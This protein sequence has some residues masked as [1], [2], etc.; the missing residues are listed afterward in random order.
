M[1]DDSLS[2]SELLLLAAAFST[3]LCSLSLSV[4]LP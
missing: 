2:N 3:L 1:R 4:F